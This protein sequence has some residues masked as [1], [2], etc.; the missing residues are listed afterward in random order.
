MKEFKA[1][2]IGVG[3]IAKRHIANLYHICKE[4]GMEPQIDVVRRKPAP[5]DETV[6]PFIHAVYTAGQTVP[7]GY[8]VIFITNPTE[9]HLDALATY[10]NKGKNFF[11]EKPLTSCRKLEE[12]FKIEYRE[13]AIYYVACPVRYNAVVQY[14]KEYIDPAKVISV[15]CMSSSYLP[16]WRPGVDYRNTYSAHKDLGGGVSIDLIHEW[17]YLKFLFGMPEKLFY[18]YGQKSNLEMDCED[19]AIYVADYPDKVVELHL[20]YFGRKTIREIMLFTDEDT[21]IGDLA[22]STVTYLKEGKT[23]ELHQDRNGFQMCEMRHFLDIL[24]GKISCDNNIVDAY[25]TI[26]LTQGM[27]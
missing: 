20:D 24:E 25:Q 21:I 3:S 7:D 1:C 4:R 15:R 17:D 6:A 14:I 2:F 19:Y 23:I 8:D 9:F 10:H 12:T 16:E 13:D 22:N 11:I 18:T 5:M 26:K 27:V